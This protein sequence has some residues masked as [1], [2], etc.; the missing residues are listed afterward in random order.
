M[1]SPWAQDRSVGVPSCLVGSQGAGKTVIAC[2][3]AAALGYGRWRTR[4]LFCFAD[5]TARDLLQRRSTTATGDTVWLDSP[6][7]EAAKFGAPV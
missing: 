2:A 1:T 5:M 4:G 3:A 6:V 7:V